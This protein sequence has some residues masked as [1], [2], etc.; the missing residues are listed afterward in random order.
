MTSIT[1]VQKARARMLLQQPFFAALMLQMPLV[2]D[3]TI[4]AAGA[5]D[6]QRIFINPE[7]TKNWSPQMMETLLAHEVMHPILDHFVR[8]QQMGYQRARWNAATDYA[9]NAI[10]VA[11]NFTALP[12]WLYD[13]ALAHMTADQIYRL[14][15]QEQDA[16]GGGGAGEGEGDDG[17]D[18]GEGDDGE[19]AGEGAGARPSPNR[20]PDGAIGPDMLPA[21]PQSPAELAR[22]S[23]Q[24]RQMIAQAATMA[25]A[26]G[27]L[28]PSLQRLVD[29]ILSPVVPWGDLLREYMAQ[30]TP[31]DESWARRNRRFSVYLPARR[32]ERMGEIVVIGDTSGSI[33]NAELSRMASEIVAIADQ[34]R[35]ER[36]RLVWADT[37]VQHE[38]VFEAHE[39]MT[40]EPKGFGGTDMRVPLAYVEQ[41]EPVV[42]VLMT[43]GFTPWPDVEPPY[44]LVVCCTTDVQAPVGVTIP[45]PAGACTA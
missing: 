39:P 36:I 11:N 43:D 10:L 8:M 19:D 42:V 3:D 27:A 5:T 18:E 38:Q 9:I 22:Q 35:P 6:G 24:H 12:G 45:V 32:T 44:P 30:V 23:Q 2:L 28:T 15:E 31:D 34:A 29:S 20:E 37:C 26:A 40:F 14:L 33:S 25:R 16:A 41:F 21:P 1:N 4:P 13:P 17:E 7:R